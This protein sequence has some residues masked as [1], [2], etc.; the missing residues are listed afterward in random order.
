MKSTNKN[1]TNLLIG[2]LL[3]LLGYFF[4]LSKTNLLH[5][6]GLLMLIY[7]CFVTI[8]KFSKLTILLNGRFKN[9]RRFEDNENLII[10]LF[11]KELLEL[12]IKDGKDI[13]FEI[14]YFG[15]FHILDYNNNEENDLKN[16]S[17]IKNEIINFIKNEINPDYSID[18]LIPIA[19]NN[20]FGA[21]FIGGK[22]TQIIYVDI[23]NSD[24]K[25]IVL[26]NELNF[27]LDIK[28]IKLKSDNYYYNGLMQLE[29]I[30]SKDKFFYGVPDCIFE[31]KNYIDVFEKC[32][33]LLDKKINYSI[34]EIKDFDDKYTFEL[35]IENY[36]YKTYFRRYNDYID[37][38]R[39]TLVLNEILN[40][41]NY[42]SENKFYIL[43]YQFCDFGIVL[44]N[45]NTY[46]KLKEN[47]CINFDFQNQELT[48]KEKEKINKYSD[49]KTEIDNIEFYIKVAKESTEKTLKKGEQY[50]LS[51]PTEYIFNAGEIEMI[52]K[53]LNILIFKKEGEYEVFFK[54]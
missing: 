39:I 28:K 51:Y 6:F 44:A 26:D 53:K 42:D 1:L 36:I 37:S 46:K 21:L 52:N 2:I 3:I 48:I 29:E 24:F 5:Y 15:L 30:V 8:I 27:Y 7:G 12:R 17:Y 10:P 34:L 45:L 49:L 16:P 31:S 14:P 35:N 20:N 11:I 54:Y 22:K 9:I 41:I 19:Y 47:G 50:H 25:P 23:N 43:S 38:D 13:S 18:S 33:N 32:F 4:Y 40:L